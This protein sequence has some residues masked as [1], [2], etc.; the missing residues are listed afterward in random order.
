MLGLTLKPG[1]CLHIGP[2]ITVHVKDRKSGGN[3][4]RLLID[5]PRE[6]LV[7]QNKLIDK[8]AAR[9]LDPADPLSNL[10]HHLR[11]QTAETSAATA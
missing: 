3:S 9:P 10:A 1:Q 2:D 8:I 7:A 5:A 4:I 6:V 11:P